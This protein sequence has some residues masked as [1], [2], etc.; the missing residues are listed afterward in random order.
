METTIIEFIKILVMQCPVLGA[1]IWF[2]VHYT[3]ETEKRFIE[4]GK[5]YESSIDKVV[6]SISVRL[7]KIDDKIDDLKLQMVKNEHV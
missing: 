5:L 2:L 6:S 7:D 1:F 4:Q 3:K